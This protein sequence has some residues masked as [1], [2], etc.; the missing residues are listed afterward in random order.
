[1][2][3]WL[4]GL[5]NRWIARRAFN[6]LS[7]FAQSLDGKTYCYYSKNLCEMLDLLREKQNATN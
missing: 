2:K 1:M 5:I 7:T 6:A 3:K 4:N